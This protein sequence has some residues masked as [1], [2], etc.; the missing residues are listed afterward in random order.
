MRW[1]DAYL[2]YLRYEKNYSAHTVVAYASD[3]NQFSAY[4]LGVYRIDQP[5]RVEADHIRFWVYSLFEENV[6]KRSVQR[7]L[8]TLKSFWRYLLRKQLVQKN[9]LQSIHAPKTNKPLPVF[10]KKEEMDRL[11]TIA[12]QEEEETFSVVRDR[13][14][15]E[16]FYQLGLRLSELLALRMADVDLYSSTVKVTGKR[17]KQRLLP[18]GR[19]LHDQLESYIGMRQLQVA[20]QQAYLLVLDSGKPLY[21]T[22]VYRMVRNRLSQVSTMTK[23]SPHVLRHTF[24]TLLLNEGAELNAVKDLLGHA[25]LSATEVYT[26]TTFEE[27]KKVYKQAHPR[28]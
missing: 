23:R 27:M 28:A 26:H 6:S 5:E 1:V 3:L 13:L 19:A 22:W 12:Q 20:S 25:S 11:Q 17:N 14:I 15:I 9:P 24:A 7:K 21:A 8:S 16:L 4:V 2:Q 10:L 18:F